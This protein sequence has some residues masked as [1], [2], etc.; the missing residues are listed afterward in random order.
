M[1]SST[2]SASQNTAS[3]IGAG[4]YGDIYRLHN[5][6]VVKQMKP[7][8]DANNSTVI[9]KLVREV[10]VQ[11]YVTTMT[12]DLGIVPKISSFS[13]ANR[14]PDLERDTESSNIQCDNESSS[15][16]NLLHWED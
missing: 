13:L 15:V 11:S 4:V 7:P 1:S 12:T 6:V 10:A 16:R 9:C 2:V 14:A 5:G 8:K 3:T